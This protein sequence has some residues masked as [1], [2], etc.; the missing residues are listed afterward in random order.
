[1]SALSLQIT[2]LLKKVTDIRQV[3]RTY[4]KSLIATFQEIFAKESPQTQPPDI[5]GLVHASMALVD[6]RAK[7][8]QE[9]DEKVAK[10]TSEDIAARDVETQ[11]FEECRQGTIQLKKGLD[12]VYGPSVLVMLGL[13]GETPNDSVRLHRVLQSA[14]SALKKEK[15]LPAPIN[16]YV[17][18]WTEENLERNF[19]ALWKPLEKAV[20]EVR[21][22]S[23]ETQQAQIERRAAMAELSLV[24]N[25]LSDS[26]ENLARFAGQTEVAERIRPSGGRPSSKNIEKK[27]D[28][29]QGNTNPPENPS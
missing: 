19:E 9:A 14:S 22:E 18:S 16:P 10:E 3:Y 2:H 24:L 11:R 29:P 7:K 26:L 17:P 15:K 6:L 25:I 28:P 12:G 8:L 20:E 1:M 23:R 5:G 27:Q 21:R 4:G 13:N